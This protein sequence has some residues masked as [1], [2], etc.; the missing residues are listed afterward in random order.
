MFSL[1]TSAWNS[2][3]GGAGNALPVV[4]LLTL[5]CVKV[6]PTEG[7]VRP[8]GSPSSVTT[9]PY[10]LLA[11]FSENHRHQ[12]LHLQLEEISVSSQHR[13]QSSEKAPFSHPRCSC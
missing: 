5:C 11:R 10:C 3:G 2:D 9:L 7:T 13:L 6:S 1:K 12:L 4:T 8:L